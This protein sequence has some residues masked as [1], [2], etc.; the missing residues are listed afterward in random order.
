MR[1]ERQNGK[2]EGIEKG[3]EKGLVKGIKKGK[4]EERLGIIRRMKKEGMDKE[5]IIR[6]TKCTKKEYAAALGI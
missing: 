5:Q 6:V 4:R 2:K 1:E 3:I